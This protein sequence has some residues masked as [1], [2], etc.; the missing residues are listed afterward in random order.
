MFRK[1]C[2][3]LESAAEIQG[4]FSRRFGR[5]RKAGNF[6]NVPRSS[7]YFAEVYKTLQNTESEIFF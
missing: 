7:D 3:C 2:A 6:E 1:L 5:S 4:A